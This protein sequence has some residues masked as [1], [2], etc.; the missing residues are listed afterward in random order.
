MS[1][2][3]GLNTSILLKLSKIK[4]ASEEGGRG[5]RKEDKIDCDSESLT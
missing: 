1:R 5:G 4:M 2:T 3:T